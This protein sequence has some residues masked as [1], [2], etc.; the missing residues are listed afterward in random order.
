[1]F[2]HHLTLKGSLAGPGLLIASIPLQ[3]PSGGYVAGVG[4]PGVP[5]GPPLADKEG[6]G[7]GGDDASSGY[8]SPPDP[9]VCDAAR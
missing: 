1:M 6:G 2:K 4:C 5:A 3:S 8:G 9:D 7:T